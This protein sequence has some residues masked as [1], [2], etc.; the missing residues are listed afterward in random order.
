MYL[1]LGAL[2]AML[3]QDLSGLTLLPA[4][5]SRHATLN[6]M[7]SRDALVEASSIQSAMKMCTHHFGG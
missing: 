3:L 1:Q 6:D 4:W 5:R 2:Q 7:D